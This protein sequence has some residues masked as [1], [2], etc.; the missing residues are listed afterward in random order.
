MYERLVAIP[1]SNRVPSSGTARWLRIAR[2]TR[3]SRVARTSSRSRI[4]LDGEI[5]DVR[6]SG[7]M[8][9]D[10]ITRR[11]KA[12]ELSRLQKATSVIAI[13]SCLRLQHAERGRQANEQPKD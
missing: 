8:G 5:R 13:N 9:I 6:G 10:K 3:W 7:M 12:S 4:G 11:K 2:T 1:T